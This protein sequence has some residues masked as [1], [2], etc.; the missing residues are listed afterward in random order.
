MRIALGLLDSV[1]GFYGATT[2]RIVVY[3]RVP[4]VQYD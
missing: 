4:E 3:R 1:L 2:R